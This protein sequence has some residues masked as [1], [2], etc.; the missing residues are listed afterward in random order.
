MQIMPRFVYTHIAFFGIHVMTLLIDENLTIW[1][2]G[3]GAT[4]TTSAGAG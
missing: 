1:L 2:S 4:A 3:V